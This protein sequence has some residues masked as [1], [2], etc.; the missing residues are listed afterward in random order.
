MRPKKKKNTHHE[1][2]LFGNFS[3]KRGNDD[4]NVDIVND[5][6]CNDKKKTQTEKGKFQLTC[7]RDVTPFCSNV[8]AR[9]G[10]IFS[11]LFF[12]QKKKIW[13]SFHVALFTVEKSGDTGA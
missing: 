10:Y 9:A 13:F 7:V 4:V 1:N 12:C 8:R 2:G 11:F 3:L 6:N 5:M